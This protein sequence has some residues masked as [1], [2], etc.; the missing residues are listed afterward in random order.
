MGVLPDDKG[1]HHV[2]WRWA[3]LGR[4]PQPLAFKDVPG[5]TVGIDDFDPMLGK[6]GLVR[7]FPFAHAD[8]HVEVLFEERSAARDKRPRDLPIAA[9]EVEVAGWPGYDGR[10][11]G[12][13]A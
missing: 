5:R 11:S 13:A 10:R 12:N 7:S 3:I 6:L 4:L 2:R 8:R 1:R 9:H